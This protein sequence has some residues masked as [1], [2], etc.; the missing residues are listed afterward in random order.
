MKKA[1]FTVLSV[2][3]LISL[4]FAQASFAATKNDILAEAKKSPVFH[5]VSGTV[6]KLMEQIEITSEEADQVVSA[7][8]EVNTVITKDNGPSY[9]DASGKPAYTV[10]QRDA[11]I[12]SMDKV[13]ATLDITYEYQAVSQ[14][15]TNDVKIVFKDRQTG[16]VLASYD[17]D[18]IKDTSSVVEETS[19]VNYTLI[20]ISGV[21]VAV[22]AVAYIYAKKKVLSK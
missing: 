20:A 10:A 1:L 6:T 8:K 13:C 14:G 4:V 9:T 21:L 12:K 5:Y 19:S 16:N 22:S 17:G 7:I 18:P 11:I 2:A 15:N 3:M